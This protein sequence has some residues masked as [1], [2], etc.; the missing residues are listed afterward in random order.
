MKKE[1]DFEGCLIGIGYVI[2]FFMEKSV[3]YVVGLGMAYFL[4]RF[5][6]EI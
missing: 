6:F 3:P 5:I 1:S 4:I 2:V